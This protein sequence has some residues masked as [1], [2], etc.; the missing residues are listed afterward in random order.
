MSFVG[1]S[2]RWALTLRLENR[3]QTQI[4]FHE[5][6]RRLKALPNLRDTVMESFS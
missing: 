4:A 5:F 6:I 3:Q 1:S 2:P